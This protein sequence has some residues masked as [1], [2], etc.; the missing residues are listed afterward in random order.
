[1]VFTEAYESIH[2]YRGEG[3]L[4]VWLN[5]ITTYTMLDE[6]R[7]KQRWNDALKRFWLERG[8]DVGQVNPLPDDVFD[9]EETQQMV[10]Q[11]LGGIDSQ[12][13]IV[14]LL[15]DLEGLGIEEAANELDIPVGTVASRLYRGRQLLKKRL[16]TE[17][18]R[19][20]LSVEEWF[21]E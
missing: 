10:H 11:I 16:R 9:T 15:C 7:R 12:K 14:I 18:N 21:H 1:M 4:F 8:W 6:F 5:R 13:R 20:G 17:M 19:R 3:P 2:R